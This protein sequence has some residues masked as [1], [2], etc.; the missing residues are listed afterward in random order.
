MEDAPVDAFGVPMTQCGF[1]S[2]H[3]WFRTVPGKRFCSRGCKQADSQRRMRKADQTRERRRKAGAEAGYEEGHLYMIAPTGD[4]VVKVGY[5]KRLKDRFRV[6]QTAH[7]RPLNLIASI[8]VKRFTRNDPPDK[9]IHLLLAD[10][11][12]VKGEWWITSDHTRK[13]LREA[14]FEF[15]D[16]DLA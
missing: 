5:S 7:Y 13:T 14:G 12:H 9:E 3:E 15:D 10:E 4:P 1:W 6:L 8:P 11:D 16:E 2:C